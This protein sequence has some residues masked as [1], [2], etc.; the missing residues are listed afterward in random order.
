MATDIAKIASIFR[1]HGFTNVSV[2]SDYLGLLFPIVAEGPAGLVRQT[3][4]VSVFR[5]LDRA[6][7]AIIADDFKMLDEKARSLWVGKIFTYCVL[8]E[9]WDK[10][11][12]CSLVESIRQNDVTP[13]NFVKGGG[14]AIVLVNMATKEVR[15]YIPRLVGIRDLAKA[16][17]AIGTSIKT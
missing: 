9:I 11:A 15:S 13:S 4:L 5:F 16:V 8:V 7:A 1:S 6:R 12:V 14:G 3:V 17:A 2:N 10:D